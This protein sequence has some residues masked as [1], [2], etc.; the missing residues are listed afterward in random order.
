MEGRHAVTLADKG[1][2]VRHEG[3]LE[4]GGSADR[5]RGEVVDSGSSETRGHDRFTVC[6]DLLTVQCDHA[7]V[8]AVNGQ[9]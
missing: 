8:V 9:L 1:V 7:W 4:G 6:C 5:L 2:E 3:G